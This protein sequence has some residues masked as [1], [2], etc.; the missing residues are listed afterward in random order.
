MGD[1]AN[2]FPL[3]KV[4]SLVQFF[5]T[6]VLTGQEAKHFTKSDLTPLPKPEVVQRLYMRVLQLV[7]RIRAESQYLVPLSENIQQPQLFEGAAPIMNLFLRM[8]QFLPMC[9]VH[10]FSL[11]DLTAPKLK[12]TVTIMSGIVNFL[13]FRN[14][15]LEVTLA[16][17][18][19][20]RENL[21]RQ[22]ACKQGIRE[23]EKRI[24]EL[25]TIPPEQQAEA[26][27]LD[28]AVAELTEN[29]SQRYPEVN[30]LQ[31]EVAD[32]KSENAERAQKLSQL[33]MDV[34]TQKEAISKLKSQIVESPEDLKNE[35]M[36]MKDTIQNDKSTKDAKDERLVE[37]QEFRQ[38]VDRQMVEF[39]L[40][41]KLLQDLQVA[42]AKAQEQQEEIQ[43][44]LR[45]EEQLGKELKGVSAEEGQLKRALALKQDKESK[46]SIRRQKR[47]EGKDHHMRSIEGEYDRVHQK[48]EEVVG[49]IEKLTMEM[50]QF[51]TKIQSMRDTCGQET[52]KAQVMYDDLRSSLDQF[53]KRLENVI[54]D[55]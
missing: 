30:S 55:G 1:N 5:R 23:A 46:Q 50:K 48:R 9:F 12:Q 47:K 7:F 54:V 3:Y 10:D 24:K 36:K 2:T 14:Q 19:S 53:H 40:Y 51:K 4:D 15:R 20:F 33:K 45:A 8:R 18:Q 38:A 43:T 17:Q 31:A 25:T 6:E 39:Q 42:I 41:N 28:K 34:S 16:N 49:K 35:M 27:E 22:K 52:Q 11:A 13:H 29:T 21:D 32:G 26:K 44:G 37:N